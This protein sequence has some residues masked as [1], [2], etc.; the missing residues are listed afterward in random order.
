MSLWAWKAP[1][2]SC[3]RALP[4]LSLILRAEKN[5]LARLLEMTP[6]PTLHLDIGSGSGD[7]LPL[8]HAS[9]RL[10]CMDS[11]LAM[12]RRL[13]H[14]LKLAARA[15]QLPF[16]ATTFDLI[17]AVGVLEYV[18]DDARFFEEAHRVLQ[19]QGFFLF[20]SSPRAPANYLRMLSGERLYLRS[21]AQVRAALLAE[22]WR[23]VAHARTFMQEQWLVQR[24]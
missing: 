6:S 22:S 11:S 12:L 9:T 21:T 14:A 17:S 4:L 10:L 18:K 13:P 15:E 8:F 23:V 24:M 7:S 2:Y 3:I 1:L 19:P 16:A 5:Q 20:T